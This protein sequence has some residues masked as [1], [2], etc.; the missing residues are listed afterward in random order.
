MNTYDS[1]F[2]FGLFILAVGLGFLLGSRAS[3]PLN[4][5]SEP[6]FIP[7]MQELLADTDKQSLNQL[8]DVER[9]SQDDIELLFDLGKNLR[10][11]GDIGQATDLHQSL[12]ARTDLSKTILQRVKLELAQDFAHA[13]LLDRAESLFLELLQQGVPTMLRGNDGRS[14]QVDTSHR[15]VELYEDE[16]DWS[17]IV[18]IFEAKRLR[19]DASLNVRI[20][21]AYCE[22]AEQHI[23]NSNFLQAI[24]QC[25]LASKVDGHCSRAHIIQGDLAFDAKEFHEAIRCYLRA[26]ERDKHAI[27]HLLERLIHAFNEVQDQVGQMQHLQAY[28]RQQN[29]VPILHALT[30]VV[31]QQQGSSS[32]LDFLVDQLKA[33]PS[34]RGFHLLVE[35]AVKHD[36]KLDQQQLSPISE[37]LDEV[38]SSSPSY[39]CSHCGLKTQQTYW[40]C[41]SCKQWG[42]IKSIN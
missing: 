38:V 19:C 4:R 12:F 23:N 30:D 35:F 21:H 25:R 24:T 39:T 42:T 2:L 31:V 37:I 28:W 1:L 8:L 27:L 9:F 5:T 20:A 3:R 6:E 41:H 34:N 10:Q 11:R 14:L 17:R 15:L 29:Y 26:M 36:L 16:K 32:A 13:G 33:A 40:R 7:S 22:L 18:Q